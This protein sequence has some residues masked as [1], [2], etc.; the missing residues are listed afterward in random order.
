VSNGSAVA[1]VVAVVGVVALA[2]LAV[3]GLGGMRV[4]AGVS[5]PVAGYFGGPPAD[6]SYGIVMGSHQSRSGI[7]LFGLTIGRSRW[8]ASIALVPPEGCDVSGGE[9]PAGGP[10]E[11]AA[12]TGKISGGGTTA[13]GLEFVIVSTEVSEGCHRA[14]EAFDRWPSNQPACNE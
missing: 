12:A 4:E 9:L 6:G 3:G 14:L 2:A 11:A 1:V 10:C 8:E 13:S 7:G 5:E